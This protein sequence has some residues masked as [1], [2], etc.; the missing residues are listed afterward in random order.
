DTT[1]TLNRSG[2]A[3]FTMTLDKVSGFAPLTVGVDL[4]NRLA[5]AY[6]ELTLDIDGDGAIDY[7]EEGYGLPILEREFQ[8]TYDTPGIY[9]L[10]LT[11]TRQGGAEIIYRAV[12]MVHVQ[13]VA[14]AADALRGV[15]VGMLQ[16]LAA[17]D[18]T[19]V[20]EWLTNTIRDRYADVF[21][22]LSGVLP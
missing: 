15:F 22:R 20:A 4:K 7:V 10:T 16:R 9:P 12:R 6:D 13:S 11:L 18:V 21:S 14:E 1:L 2:T 19:G 17:G 5:Y 3:P 8:V